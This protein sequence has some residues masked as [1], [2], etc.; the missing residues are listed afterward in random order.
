[1]DLKYQRT[2][3]ISRAPNEGDIPSEA[4]AAI[5]EPIQRDKRWLSDPVLAVMGSDAETAVDDSEEPLPVTVS[6]ESRLHLRQLTKQS[7]LG[8]GI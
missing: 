8:D 2:V 4:Q 5:F 7:F 3:W 1:V 6:Q